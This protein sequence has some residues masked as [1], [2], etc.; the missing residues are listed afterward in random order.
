M[1]VCLMGIIRLTKGP[2]CQ[3][4]LIVLRKV[5]RVDWGWLEVYVEIAVAYCLCYSS[6]GRSDFRNLG[7]LYGLGPLMYSSLRL[8]FTTWSGK[9]ANSS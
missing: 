8:S 3:S 5:A 9:A 4:H 7:K 2:G 1:V 6:K